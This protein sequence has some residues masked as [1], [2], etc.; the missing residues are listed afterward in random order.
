MKN[1][2]LSLLCCF[3][4]LASAFCFV[5]CGNAEL[6]EFE[7]IIFADDTIEYDGESHSLTVSGAPDFATVSYNQNGFEKRWFYSGIQP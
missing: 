6:K 7:N 5:A 1:K 4:L 3:V 2:F